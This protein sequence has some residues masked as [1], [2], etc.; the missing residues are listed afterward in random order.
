MSGLTI[1]VADLAGHPGAAKEITAAPTVAGLAGVLGKV[2]NDVVRLRLLAESVVEG[3]QVSGEV[4]GTFE[5]E[6]SRCLVE[7]HRGFE[8]RVDETFFFG[9]ADERDGYEMNGSTIDLEQMVRDVVVLAIPTRP[10][11]AEG[12][13]GLCPVCGADRNVSDCG[14]RPDQGDFRWAPLKDLVIEEEK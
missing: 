14:H 11:H 6:C 4:S 5:L 7:F 10:L 3:I 9:G 8:R 13:K 2:T 1:H 12:C